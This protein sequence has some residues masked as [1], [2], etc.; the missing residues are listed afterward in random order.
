MKGDKKIKEHEKREEEKKYKE[1]SQ[2]QREI[3]GGRKMGKSEEE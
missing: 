2:L 1:K 3:R